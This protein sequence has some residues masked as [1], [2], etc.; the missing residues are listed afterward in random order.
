MNQ[1]YRTTLITNRLYYP[2][3]VWVTLD[4]YKRNKKRL[5]DYEETIDEVFF[6]YVDIKKTTLT[7]DLIMNNF[8]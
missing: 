2:E 4:K 7:N 1:K 5:M 3:L 8:L 6:E